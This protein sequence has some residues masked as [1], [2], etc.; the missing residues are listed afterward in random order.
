VPL[1]I[2]DHLKKAVLSA[3]YA[4]IKQVDLL[5]GGSHEGTHGSSIRRLI[6]QTALPQLDVHMSE[7]TIEGI[8]DRHKHPRTRSRARSSSRRDISVWN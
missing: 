2:Y 1:N 3:S 8:W 7:R 6:V 5:N 4:S